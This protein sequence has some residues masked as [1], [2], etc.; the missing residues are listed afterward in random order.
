LKR[1]CLVIAVGAFFGSQAPVAATGQ[2]LGPKPEEVS[3]RPKDR[4][5][6][7]LPFLATDA[8]LKCEMF[9]FWQQDC[10]RSG[11]SDPTGAYHRG[12][13]LSPPSGP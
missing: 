11:S 9:L 5:G 2:T 12:Y 8:T 1:I 3:C 7:F 4:D 13:C 10:G 6:K